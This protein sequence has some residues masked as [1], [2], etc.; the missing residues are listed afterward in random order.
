M[1]HFKFYVKRKDLLYLNKYG[2][3]ACKCKEEYKVLHKHNSIVLPQL[4]QTELLFG[5]HNKM[6][7]Q[8]LYSLQQDTGAVPMAWLE[9]GLQKVDLCVFVMS[10]DKDPRKLSFPLRLIVSLGFTEAVQI[11]LA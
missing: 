11:D 8:A 10:T 6:G 4:H 7:Y 9:E 1:V 3:V 5:S 2:I